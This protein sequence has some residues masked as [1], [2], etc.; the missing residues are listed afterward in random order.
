MLFAHTMFII[1]NMTNFVFKLLETCA[2]AVHG[3][4]IL[5][6]IVIAKITL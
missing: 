4:C 6:T 1:S 5:Y 3:S 2:I